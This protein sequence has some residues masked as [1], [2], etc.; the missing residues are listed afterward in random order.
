MSHSC[1]RTGRAGAG[2]VLLLGLLV[3]AVGA[4]SAGRP[5]PLKLT[6]GRA[7]RMGR[8]TGTIGGQA[9][10]VELRWQ[11]PDSVVGSFYYHRRGAAYGLTYQKSRSKAKALPL[12][13]S[14]NQLSY[15]Q[16]AGSWQLTSRPP[17]AVLAGSWTRP[18]HPALAFELHENYAGAVRYTRQTLLLTGGPS[19][20]DPHGSRV[21]QYERTFLTLAQPTAVPGR[22]R[23]ALASSPATRRHHMLAGRE[24]DADAHVWMEVVL[25]DFGL[26]SYQTSYDALPFGGRHQ[27]DLQSALFAVATGQPLTVASQLRPG[28]E[29]PLRRLLSRHLLHDDDPYFDEV[30][31]E[32]NNEWRWRNKQENPGQLVPLPDLEEPSADDLTLTAAGLE[33]CYS[34]YS[35]FE[36][37]GG[38]LP[39]CTV[40]VPYRELRPLVRPGTPLARMLRARGL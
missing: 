40:L 1:Y 12:L 36:S 31:K 38:M 4:V 27:S 21:P 3:A 15:Y 2:A 22:L 13:V 25:N 20:P 9:V 37:P 5:R 11:Q 24:G 33:A 17:S 6:Q 26:F 35:L 23:R 34:P 19:E 16:P 30:N 8:Y 29:R 28:Y 7:E 32:H 10:T 39:S 18:G 14:N